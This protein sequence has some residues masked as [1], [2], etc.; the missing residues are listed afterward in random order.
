M[1]YNIRYEN[2]ESEATRAKALA[3]VAEYLGKNTLDKVKGALVMIP[4]RQARIIALSFVGV[5]GYPAEVM[6]DTF[7]PG[8]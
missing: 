6:A 2:L 3:D 1:H 5:Q 7:K 4:K 8:E